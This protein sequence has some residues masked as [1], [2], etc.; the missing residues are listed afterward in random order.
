MSDAQRLM[1][2]RKP[3]AHCPFVQ[4]NEF[5]LST[6]R[7]TQIAESLRRGETF[8][9]HATIDYGDEDADTSRSSRCFGA[10][11]VLHKGGDAAMQLEQIAY[12]LGLVG[13]ADTT[14]LESCGTYADL[15]DFIAHGD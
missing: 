14:M 5:P 3:C 10:A 6:E 4:A 1:A 12:R 7:R 8:H 15:D 9:C 13:P 11:S 2:L